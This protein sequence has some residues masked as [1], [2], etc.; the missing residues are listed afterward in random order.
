[1][2]KLYTILLSCLI[3]W[4][5]PSLAQEPDQTVQLELELDSDNTYAEVFALPDSSLLLYTKTTEGWLTKATFGFAKY[6]HQ[7]K[8][9]WQTAQKI[10]DQSEYVQ[11]YTEAPFTYFL[12]DTEDNQEYNLVKLNLATGESTLTEFEIPSINSI[13]EFKVLEGNFFIIATDKKLNKLAK[14]QRREKRKQK[15]RKVNSCLVLWVWELKSHQ[16]K[17]S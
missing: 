10:D 1:M 15:R 16:R 8:K 13:E 12:F 14:R 9:V 2:I 6:N 4:N 11:H 5:F 3:L 7:L 17:K